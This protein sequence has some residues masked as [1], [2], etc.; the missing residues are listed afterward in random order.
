MMQGKTEEWSYVFQERLGILCEDRVPT[1][2]E[3]HL[4]SEDACK[5]DF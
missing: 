5:A 1:M 4:A 3:L 2:L